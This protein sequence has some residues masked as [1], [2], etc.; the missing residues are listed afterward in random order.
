MLTDSEFLALCRRNLSNG[1]DDLLLD[2]KEKIEELKLIEVNQ[3]RYEYLI[4][5]VYD[6]FTPISPETGVYT[7]K[8][9]DNTF[10]LRELAFFLNEPPV[11]SD[12]ILDAKSF[13]SEEP[14]AELIS[15]SEDPLVIENGE[16]ASIVYQGLAPIMK[17]TLRFDVLQ[18]GATEQGAGLKIY[19]KLEKL[20]QEAS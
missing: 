18:V 2:L 4:I 6:E 19:I 20:V 9:P 1:L 5:D 3:N 14:E 16:L 7:F 13:V 17:R 11:G 10:V 12:F 8:I 15:I